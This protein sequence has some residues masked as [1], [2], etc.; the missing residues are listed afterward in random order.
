[1]GGKTG[2]AEKAVNGKYN[3]NANTASFIEVLTTI[4]SKYI[5]LI[6]IDK[7]QDIHRTGGIIAAPVAKDITNKIAPILNITPEM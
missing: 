7:P 1:M 2:S 6:V 5:A 4:D 3:K